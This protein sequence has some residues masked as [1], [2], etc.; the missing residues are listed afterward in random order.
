[1]KKLLRGVNRLLKTIG[2]PP[3][4]NE[5]DYQYSEEAKLAS[6]QIEDTLEQVL[7]QGFK[8]NTMLAINLQPDI[9]KYISVPPNA[10]VMEFQDKNLT[11]N[12]GMVFDRVKFTNQFDTAII[13]D[14]IYTEDF[15]YIPPVI[16]EYIIAKA[17]YVFQKD[18][19]GDTNVNTELL[20]ELQEATKYL[21][22]YKIDQAQANARSDYFARNAN[23]TRES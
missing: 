9:N 21:N 16:Q 13:A 22:I 20:R 14:V 2:E 10:L 4:L 3:L 19:I 11:I 6:N 7:G 17:S 5:D 15:E 1:M 23:P 8:F 12:D 18:S